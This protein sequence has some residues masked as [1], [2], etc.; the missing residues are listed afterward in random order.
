MFGY[1]RRRLMRHMA[2]V[3]KGFIR[4]QVLELL[5]EKPM[6]GSEMMGEI[7]DR[8]GGRWRPS[9]GSIYPLLTWLQDEGYVIETPSE[10]NGMKRYALTSKGKTLL[11]ED[12]KIKAHLSREGMFFGPPFMGPPWLRMSRERAAEFRESV[13]RFMIAFLEF[14]SNFEERISEQA[15]DET[16]KLLNET[17]AKLEEINRKLK[18]ERDD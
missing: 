4:F 12:K 1:S 9:P 15:L 11:E 14:G 5:D 17:T 7:E 6:S 2:L 18:G 16:L 3:P 13:K 8:T 10:G